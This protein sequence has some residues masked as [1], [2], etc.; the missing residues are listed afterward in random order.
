MTLQFED[1]MRT[2]DPA[3]GFPDYTT[4]DRDR[5]LAPAFAQPAPIGTPRRHSTHTRWLTAVAA[6]LLAIGLLVVPGL[7]LFPSGAT[8]A[9]KGLLDKA[10]VAAVDPP[11]RPDQYWRITV[12]SIT[13]DS[14][15]P[16]GR[17]DDPT[18]AWAL[19]HTQRISYVAV[20]G[21]RPSWYVDRTGPF[22]RQISGPPMPL[23]EED[24][25]T[26]EVWTTN[27]SAREQDYV[28]ILDLPTD[29]VAL[30]AELYRLGH[31]QGA[32]EDEGVLEL[33]AG[34]LQDGY[35]PAALRAALFEVLKTIP[36]VDLVDHNV[37]LDGRT[38]VALGRAEPA[39]DGWRH[40]LI[41]DETTAEFIG[42]RHVWDDQ[43]ATA[44]SALSRELVDQVDPEVVATAQ[45]YDCEV[46][47]GGVVRCSR[48]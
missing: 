46:E 25:T 45:H 38:G 24:W 19:R 5:L 35:A 33:I 12:N 16:E 43:G 20:D 44:E 4:D 27:L 32:S 7:G 34:I 2:A 9:A 18:S 1:L 14:L 15:D 36:G 23:P 22:I 37:T 21:S 40:E 42:E 28:G 10:V 26:T 17:L 11:T 31:D 3:R 30:R 41:F 39:R 48:R 13:N 47:T 8:A 29:P 6:A